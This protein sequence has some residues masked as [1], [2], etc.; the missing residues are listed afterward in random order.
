[1]HLQPRRGRVLL[2][3]EDLRPGAGRAPGPVALRPHVPGFQPGVL[4]H[5]LP[6]A[7]RDAAPDL[8]WTFWNLASTIGAFLI[9]LSFVV[10][11]VNVVKTTRSAGPAGA[12]PWDGR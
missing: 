4:S 6:G 12:D 2:V 11:L 1:L 3:A 10:F 7:H 9:A 5:A 8:H